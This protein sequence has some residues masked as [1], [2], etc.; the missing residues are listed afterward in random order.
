M[1]TKLRGKVTQLAPGQS[2][3][4]ALV[5]GQKVKEDTSI[6]TEKGSFA[7]IQFDDGSIIFVGPESKVIVVAMD[8]KGNGVVGLLKGKMRSKVES[9]NQKKFFVRTR[10]AAMGVRGTEF[11]T[12]F[13]PKN[14]ITSLVTYKGEVAMASVEPMDLSLSRSQK[15]IERDHKNN[16]VLSEEQNVSKSSEDQIERFLKAKGT[17]KVRGGQLS[18]TVQKLGVASQPIRISPAQ[19]NALYKNEEYKEATANSK[20]LE[21]GKTSEKL[22]IVSV[23]QKVAAEGV[24]DPKNKVFAAKSGGLFDLETGLYIAP[25]REALY[26]QK[27]KIY[28]AQNIGSVDSAT[29]QYLAP[30]GLDLDPV[31][32]FKEK[33]F[34]KNAPRE[35]IARVQNQRKRLNENMAKDVLMA[36]KEQG[37][38][39]VAFKPLSTRELISKNV[40]SLSLNSYEQSIDQKNDTFLQAPRSFE[41]DDARDIKLA[42]AFASGSRWQPTSFF[43]SKKVSIPTQQRGSFSQ[44]GEN[45]V[46][47]GL[48]MR[49]SLA[50]RW[51]LTSGVSLSQEY[52]LHHSQTSS[53]TSSSFI[54]VTVPQLNIGV[55]GTLI[56]S[57]R[58]TLEGQVLVGTNLVK[59]T[60][61]HKLRM[62]LHYSTMLSARYW[63]SQRYFL[64]LGLERTYQSNSTEGTTQVYTSKVIRKNLGAL[65]NLG[66]YF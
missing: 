10:N 8:S 13:N 54:R 9:R 23:A 2:F 56:R 7:K 11:E 41:V 66:S 3:A 26:D 46:S 6:V 58:F 47:L 21:L 25:G 59:E 63:V 39:S 18:Q 30:L 5:M 14:Q 19:V 34:T 53:G 27:N 37:N 12:V 28:V 65:V 55:T 32:G 61:D 40:L 44:V 24:F 38:S 35:L 57:G 50:S 51:S 1:V 43:S 48:G 62:G 33:G 42:L 22:E 15:R 20:Q 52:F 60:G 49:Y 29:G 4:R 36:P 16:V 64:G 31:D 17:V 45:L